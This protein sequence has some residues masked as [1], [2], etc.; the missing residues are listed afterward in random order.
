MVAPSPFTTNSLQLLRHVARHSKNI[1][2]YREI[3]PIEFVLHPN[4]EK[5][6]IYVV[7]SKAA[8]S[9][10]KSTFLPYSQDD[11]H[12]S[13]HN[14]IKSI[15]KNML[16]QS[17]S[18]YFIFT[19]VRNPYSRLLSCY[20][21]K[22]IKEAKRNREHM[23]FDFYLCGYLKNCKSFDD[24]IR[25]VVNI[26]TPLCD[27][28]FKPQT[29]LLRKNGFEFDFVGRIEEASSSFTEIKEKFRLNNLPQYNTTSDASHSLEEIYTE[30]IQELVFNRYKQDFINFGYS[31]EIPTE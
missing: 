6:I 12:G 23:Y 5:K 20:Q 21:D 15:K 16:P 4:R 18:E 10:I 8:C 30:S 28:H 1:V 26:P 7:N 13:V 27:R 24:F 25:R 3:D 14:N 17:L 11:D 2:R 22:F 31:Y 19:Y 9:S 29:T